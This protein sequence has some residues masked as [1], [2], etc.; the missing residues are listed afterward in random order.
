MVYGTLRDWYR[1]VSLMCRLLERAEDH[2]LQ[3]A[4]EVGRSRAV[5]EE[6][7]RDKSY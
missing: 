5:R 6:K 3:F 1:Y 4:I 7:I 2:D